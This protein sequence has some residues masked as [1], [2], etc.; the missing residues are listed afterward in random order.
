MNIKHLP[1]AWVLIAIALSMSACSAVQSANH[2]D[3]PAVVS[4]S[5]PANAQPPS[6]STIDPCA[7]LTKADA[8]VALGQP[9]NDAERPTQEGA[10]DTITACRYKVQ[11]SS[12]YASAMV[13]VLVPLDGQADSAKTHFEAD[14]KISQ[15]MLGPTLDV[16]G[17]GDSAYWVGSSANQLTVLRGSVR[18]I[19]N[20]STATG[21][22]APQ[23]VIDLSKVML[24][25]L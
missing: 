7:L 14:K 17:V 6:N 25:R 11:D 10:N 24:G 22:T 18:F 12:S 16:P 3:V 23:S 21:D 5:A 1:H 15:S 19:L 8:E 4:T 13:V 9:V 2:V 20:V